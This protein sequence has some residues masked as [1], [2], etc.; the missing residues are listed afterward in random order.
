LTDVLGQTEVTIIR[1]GKAEAAQFDDD[2]E[3][4]ETAAELSGL[5]EVNIRIV[6]VTNN[7]YEDLLSAFQLVPQDIENIDF[8]DGDKAYIGYA[9]HEK[10]RRKTNLKLITTHNGG[11]NDR[12]NDR[13][14]DKIVK[15]ITS[16]RPVKIDG[17]YPLENII[18][19]LVY[20]VQEELTVEETLPNAY[21][22]GEHPDYDAGVDEHI[23]EQPIE[24]RPYRPHT[25]GV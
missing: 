11:T 24:N 22:P 4:L 12:L 2:F 20:I 19:A 1:Q 3:R 10:K 25:A 7:V 17:E 9:N 13:I 21:H 14:R 6:D 23:E 18:D 5:D 15:H 16:N 8:G